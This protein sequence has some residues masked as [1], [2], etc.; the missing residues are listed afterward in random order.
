MLLLT[1]TTI[2][3]YKALW[4]SVQFDKLKIERAKNKCVSFPSALYTCSMENGKLSVK[5]SFIRYFHWE[6]SI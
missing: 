5:I 1:L 4:H 3:N 6:G 2:L